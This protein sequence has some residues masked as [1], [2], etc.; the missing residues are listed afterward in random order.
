MQ[1]SVLLPSFQHFSKIQ[2]DGMRTGVK[3]TPR[4]LCSSYYDGFG[5]SEKKTWIQF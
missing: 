3:E 1:A 5:M 4:I 2:N